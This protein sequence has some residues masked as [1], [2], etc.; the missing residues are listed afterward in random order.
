MCPGVVFTPMWDNMISDYARKRN[1]SEQ[2]VE[3][4]LK[5]KIPMGRLCS[6]KDVAD[7]AVFIAGAKAA[8]ITGQALNIAGGAVMH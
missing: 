3:P 5:S 7:A 4:Y 1:I 6:A 2:D 8:Y